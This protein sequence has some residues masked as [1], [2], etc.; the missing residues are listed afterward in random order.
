MLHHRRT[1]AFS[2]C[3]ASNPLCSPSAEKAPSLVEPMPRAVEAW[4]P[5]QLDHQEISG[6]AGIESGSPFCSL[7]LCLS[8]FSSVQFSCSVV[9]DSL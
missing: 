9:S 2:P 4:S 7:L 5:I 8:Q 1:I 3:F 6:S